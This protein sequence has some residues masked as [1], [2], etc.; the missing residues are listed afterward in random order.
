MPKILV[1]L[2]NFSRPQN[3]PQV[4]RSWREQTRKPDQIVVV[5]N[6][7]GGYG[8]TYPHAFLTGA[9]DVWRIGT[10]LGC[11]CQFYPALALYEYDYVM[12]ADDD[13]L[14]GPKALAHYEEV[15]E[16]GVQFACVGETGRNFMLDAGPGKRYSGRNVPRWDK[17]TLVPVHITCRSHFVKRASVVCPIVFRDLLIQKFKDEARYLCGIHNDFLLNQGIQS[18]TPYGSYLL[19]PRDREESLFAVDMDRGSDATAGLWRRPSHFQERARMV[20]MCL[21]IGWTP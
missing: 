15:A 2:I 4:I 1:V 17:D 14:P 12:F 9:D 3:M 6:S 19:R 20:D 5:D 10:N 16:S 7:S 18:A 13:H 8:D 21:E 11:P